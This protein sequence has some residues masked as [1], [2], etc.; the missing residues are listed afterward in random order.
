[1]P[2]L[3]RCNLENFQIIL[4][5]YISNQAYLLA[6]LKHKINLIE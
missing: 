5:V 2:G 3:I 1:M 4:T 6:G